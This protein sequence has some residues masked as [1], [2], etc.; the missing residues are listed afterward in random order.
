MSRDLTEED[1]MT[2]ARVVQ[3]YVTGTLQDPILAGM[4]LNG[5]YTLYYKEL[6]FI[7]YLYS[8]T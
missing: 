2:C 4:L 5:S 1:K 8:D 6:L 3:S 7:Y